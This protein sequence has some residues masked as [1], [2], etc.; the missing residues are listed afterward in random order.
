MAT[1]PVFAVLGAVAMAIGLLARTPA[2]A[3]IGFIA[4]GMGVALVVPTVIG[5]GAQLAGSHPGPTIA[6]IGAISWTGFVLAPPA[7][8]LMSSMT[9]L[10]ATLAALPLLSVAIA[11]IT[12][13]TRLG[14]FVG[15][16]PPQLTGRADR[17]GTQ[18]A[19]C[20]DGRLALASAS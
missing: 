18:G 4:M 10:T 6:V 14:N 13:A 15:K 9:S 16:P 2:S 5:Q 20:Q 3:T 19:R 17:N 8:G 1:L 7:V 11:V 12:F